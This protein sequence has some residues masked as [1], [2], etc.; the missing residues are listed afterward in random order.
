MNYLLTAILA[1][2]N[3]CVFSQMTGDLGTSGRKLLS[4]YNFK[5]SG[6]KAGVIMM[7]VVVDIDGN[8]TSTEV[9]P[10][11][12]TIVSTPTVMKIKNEIRL[13]KFE[14]GYQ[15]PKFHHATF[16]IEVSKAPYTAG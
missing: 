16:K 5:S 3:F 7:D 6:S 13:L 9:I 1:M 12:T 10:A 8:V 11:G 4:S 14:K 15:F 2:F